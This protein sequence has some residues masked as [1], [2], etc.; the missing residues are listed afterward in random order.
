MKLRLSFLVILGIFI[1][2]ESN[3]QADTFALGIN[4]GTN[5]VGIDVTTNLTSNLN[6]KAT[7]NFFSYNFSGEIDDDPSIDI[8]SEMSTSNF[9]MLVNYYPFSDRIALVG[10]VYYLNWSVDTD[11]TPSEA[12]EVDDRVFEPEQLGS[13]N[14]LIEYPNKF[15]PYL[16]LGFGNPIRAGS[17][18]RVNAQLGLMYTGAPRLRMTGTG[19]IAPTA[20]NQSSFQEGMNEFEWYPMFNLGL[21]YRL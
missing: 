19:M 18:L 9:S 12:Y 3:A 1:Y 8:I 4:A 15:A 11:L 6:L 7:A 21:S 14:A 17:K 5:G 20:D 10:G 2:S 13:L 16:G